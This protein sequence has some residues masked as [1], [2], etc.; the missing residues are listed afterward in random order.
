MANTVDV[1]HDVAGEDPGLRVLRLLRLAVRAL[2][3]ELSDQELATRGVARRLDHK[4]AG[5]ARDGHQRSA[6]TAMGKASPEECRQVGDL[7]PKRFTADTADRTGRAERS[8]QRD[9]ERGGKI[10]SAATT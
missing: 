8:I 2:A 4:E 5:K 3:G 9:A 10:M 1:I 7:P 6:L